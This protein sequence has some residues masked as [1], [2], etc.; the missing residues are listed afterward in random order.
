MNRERGFTLIEVMV[1][2]VIMTVGVL[3]LLTTTALVTRMIARGQRS[4]VAASFATQRI[5]QLRDAG[6]VPAN[7]TAGSEMLMRGTTVIARNDW[8][9]TAIGD[10]THRVFLNVTYTTRQG[11]QRTDSMQTAISCQL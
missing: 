9:W 6:C 8:R 11:H 2:L 3:G 7:R 4:S 10:S 5:E 1:A